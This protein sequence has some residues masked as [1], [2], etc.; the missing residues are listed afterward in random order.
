[1][2]YENNK[3]IPKSINIEQAL[4]VLNA[5]S[6]FKNNMQNLGQQKEKQLFAEIRGEL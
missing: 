1:M 2:N 6:S 4:V 5:C 3:K